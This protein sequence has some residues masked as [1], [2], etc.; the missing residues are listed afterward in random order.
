MP[1][2][3][4]LQLQPKEAYKIFR[5]SVDLADAMEEILENSGRYSA[6]FAKG[7]NVSF[8]QAGSGKLK[9]IASLKDLA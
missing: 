1:K 3:K 8:K 2:V 9:R 6:E 4:T 7:L 5:M